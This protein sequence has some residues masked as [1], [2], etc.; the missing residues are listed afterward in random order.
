[1]SN[2]AILFPGQGSQSVGM[3]ATLAEQYPEIV[4]ETFD[5]AST[6]MGEDLWALTQSG[7]AEQL[8]Q[9]QYTQPALLAADVAMWRCWKTVMPVPPKYMAG[10]SLG[11]YSACV[12][13]NSMNFADGIRCVIRRGQSMQDAVPEGE[14]AMVAVIGL[15]NDS[16]H[17]LCDQARENDVLSP[18]N[19]NAI[20]QTVLAGHTPAVERVVPLANEAGARL[21][22]IL[23]VSVP[24]HC[25]LMAPAATALTPVLSEL[26]LKTPT[27]PVI[28]NVDAKT[29]TSP[30]GIRQALIA[31]LTQPVRWVETIQALVNQG[32]HDLLECGP[33][34]V[35]TGLN[36]RIDKRIRTITLS[37][38]TQW[39][40]AQD[41]L[42]Q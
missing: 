15:E 5:E 18:A 6:I 2:Y 38:L 10:H 23:P 4:S 37:N 7:P 8:N 30:D 29:H 9:T 20:G 34:N 40:T 35:L 11:E 41:A 1:M 36:R 28:H 22:K 12:C 39:S 26:A 3:L 21:V 32:I 14:G 16:L 17:R 24:S 19:Y 42:S 31:Q 33:G 25:A 27:I 13:A